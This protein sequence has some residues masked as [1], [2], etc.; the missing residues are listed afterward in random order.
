M[1]FE[2]ETSDV[3]QECLFQ[4]LSLSLTHTHTHIYIYICVCVFGMLQDN[5]VAVC[6]GLLEPHV[7]NVSCGPARPNAKH[8]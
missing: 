8:P 3:C 4:W 5:G 6:C 1:R 2:I 7:C